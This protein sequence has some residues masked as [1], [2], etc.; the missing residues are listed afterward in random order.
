MIKIFF[1][2]QVLSQGTQVLR[3]ARANI[4]APIF[5][6]PFLPEPSLRPGELCKLQY[7][8]LS[9]A[10]IKSTCLAELLDKCKNLRKLG[11]YNFFYIYK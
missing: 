10:T 7:L 6:S 4:S 11:K 5:Q 8:D 1:I 2:F 3:L 9:M